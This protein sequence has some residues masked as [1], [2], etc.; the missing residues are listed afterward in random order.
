[1]DYSIW[2]NFTRRLNEGFGDELQSDM[3]DL[4]KKGSKKATKGSPFRSADYNF[5]GKTKNQVSAPPGA[6]GGGS[7]EE[8]AD[9]ESFAFR[10]EL[11]PRIWQNKEIK[12][13]IRSALIKVAEGFIKGLPLEVQVQDIRLTGSLA[14]YNWS[15]YSDVD[16]HIVVDFASLDENKKLVKA[17]FDNARL[18]W[19]DRHDIQMKGYDVEIYVEN[20]GEDHK[21]SGIYSVLNKE[22]VVEPKKYNTTIDF[23]A[24]RRKAE[25]IE[26]RTESAANLMIDGDYEKSLRA[27]DRLKRKIKNLR[28]AGLES[29]KQEYS[30]ENIAFK[31]LRR[32]GILD[33]LDDLKIKAYDS[34]L[35]IKEVNRETY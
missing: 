4:L 19:N 34:M 24:A 5:R 21:S 29:A 1:M 2:Q 17:F 14:N 33:Y 3:D 8:D 12:Q 22:W 30:I 10:D 6:A 28:R 35:N 27:I 13:E 7:L 26:F 9:A 23:P 31:I 15:P 32:N 11:E 18:R 25:S 20:V 16:L